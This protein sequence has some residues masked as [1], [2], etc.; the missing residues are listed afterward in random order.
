MWQLRCH[1]YLV[2]LQLSYG[3][4]QPGSPINMTNGV[5][6]IL[7]GFFAF[8]VGAMRAVRALGLARWH[9]ALAL[10]AVAAGLYVA[11]AVLIQRYIRRRAP[12]FA[13]GRDWDLTAGTGIVPQWVSVIGLLSMS[14]LGAALFPWVILLIRALL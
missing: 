13:N 14:A 4:R 5:L 2:R 9:V 12:E 3:V 7:L 10:F 8:G 1:C 6:I 11:N